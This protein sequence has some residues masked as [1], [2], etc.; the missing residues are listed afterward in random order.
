MAASASRTCRST[1]SCAS[2]CVRRP[3][4]ARTLAT[5]S[6]MAASIRSSAPSSGSADTGRGIA[7]ET[8]EGEEE[9]EEEEEEKEEE[10][11]E[12]EGRPRAT[13]H[14]GCCSSV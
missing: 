10:A 2:K 6:F 13:L 5:A 12:E 1:P 14:P 7:A 3:T 8:G 11:E 4:S 9:E